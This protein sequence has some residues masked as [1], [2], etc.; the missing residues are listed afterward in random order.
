MKNIKYRINMIEIVIKIVFYIISWLK[1]Y[2]EEIYI[3]VGNKR[4]DYVE[5]NTCRSEKAQSEM[6]YLIYLKYFSWLVNIVIIVMAN[7]QQIPFNLKRFSVHDIRLNNTVEIELPNNINYYTINVGYTLKL[8]GK[9]IRNY[10][11]KMMIETKICGA[12]R[13]KILRYKI[14]GKNNK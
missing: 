13:A 11:P 10:E 6:N 7:G 5:I 9:F 12:N 2:W 8:L 4:P 1:K 3:L 14:I